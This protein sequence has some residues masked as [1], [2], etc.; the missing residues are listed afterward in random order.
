MKVLSVQ[1]AVAQGS[2]ALYDAK[3]GYE[4][5]IDIPLT[6]K[7]STALAPTIDKILEDTNWSYPD[8]ELFA[9]AVGPGSFT[10]L[11]VGIAFGKGLAL[12]V[13]CAIKAIPTLDIIRYNYNAALNPV[14]T[15]MD[16]RS[17]RIYYAEFAETIDNVYLTTSEPKLASVE[18]LLE[19]CGDS[20]L[21]IGP[22]IEYLKSLFAGSEVHI[23][24]AHPDALTLARIA[25]ARFA[26]YGGDKPADLTPVYLKSGQV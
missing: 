21:V 12:S 24:E 7:L 9:C 16:A 5:S 4:R 11:R 18:E 25:L 20:N 23:E 13:G 19:V 10:G 2:V 22:D 15:A 3:S 1:S 14:I 8:I 6:G 26:A 17:E